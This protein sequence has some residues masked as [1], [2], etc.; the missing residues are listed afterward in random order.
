MQTDQDA[1]DALLAEHA[2]R[3]YAFVHRL[4]GA[5]HAEDVCQDVWVEVYRAYPHFRGEARVSTWLLAIAARV[6]G[7]HRRRRRARPPTDDVAALSE[8][9]DERPGP[10]R[11]VLDAELATIVRQAVDML[12]D[13]QREAIH[14]RQL[15]GCSYAEVA[16]ILDVPLGTVRSRIHHGMAKLADLLGPYLEITHEAR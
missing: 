1:F 8:A 16:A 10:E 14:L 11:C 12:P 2:A 3:V 9:P 6:C 7:R 13:G 15:E 5:D 4:V